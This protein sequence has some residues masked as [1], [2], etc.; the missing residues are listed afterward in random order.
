MANQKRSWTI[1]PSGLDRACDE[2]F[3]ELL[4]RWRG[5]TGGEA[6]PVGA[7]DC[8]DHYEVRIFADVPEP[9][10]LEVEV[11]NLSLRVRVPESALPRSEHTINF[12]HPV[13]RERTTARWVQGVLTV[14]LPKQSARRVKVE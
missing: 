6:A 11:T 5:S 12:A 3:D 13:D 4:G 14:T 10:A 1:T 7:V 8:G 9:S 2:L